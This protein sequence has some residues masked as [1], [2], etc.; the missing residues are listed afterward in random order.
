MELENMDSYQLNQYAQAK[1]SLEAR[2]LKQNLMV[3]DWSHYKDADRKNI[4]KEL[5]KQAD[6]LKAQ[7][8]ARALSEDEI[9][10]IIGGLSG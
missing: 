7:T 3:S 6:P 10:S 9:K 5:N 4:I 1:V 8:K 2:E